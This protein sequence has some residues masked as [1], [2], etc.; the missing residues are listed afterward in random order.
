MAG[1]LE[2][3]YNLGTGPASIKSMEK[4]NNGL[5]R[6]VII[7]ICTKVLVIGYF[8]LSNRMSVCVGFSVCVCVYLAVAEDIANR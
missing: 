7:S 8:F 2:L 3:R 1:R 4:L 6:Q 5:L